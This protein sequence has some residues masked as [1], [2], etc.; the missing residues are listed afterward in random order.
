MPQR[1]K[2]NIMNLIEI[3]RFNIAVSGVRKSADALNVK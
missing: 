3:D 2:L 1:K